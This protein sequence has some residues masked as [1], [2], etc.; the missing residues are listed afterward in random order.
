MQ[1]HGE[2]MLGSEELCWAVQ[3][4]APGDEVRITSRPPPELS[5]EEQAQEEEE[6]EALH[7]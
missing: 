1:L 5:E 7:Q 3:M 6:L 2:F 4:H